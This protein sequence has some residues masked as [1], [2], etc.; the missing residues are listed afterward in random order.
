VTD[1]GHFLEIISGMQAS[2]DIITGEKTIM[3]YWL[4]PILRAQSNAMRER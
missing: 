1:S 3:Q 4:K 2:V